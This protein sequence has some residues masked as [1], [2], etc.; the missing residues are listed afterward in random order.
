[1]YAW[2]FHRRDPW[3]SSARQRKKRVSKPQ[4]LHPSPGKPW[5]ERRRICWSRVESTHD[6]RR[7][8]TRTDPR[9]QYRSWSKKIYRCQKQSTIGR[10]GE[11]EGRSSRRRDHLIWRSKDRF[12]RVTGAINGGKSI[13]QINEIDAR[14]CD[15]E[16]G[17]VLGKED[18][19]VGEEWMG[20]R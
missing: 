14:S 13:K 17:R 11:G 6:V 10:K 18:D 8:A 1:M 20:E 3:Q 7:T 9:H 19:T 4:G 5:G 2:D 15:I 12:L 16:R